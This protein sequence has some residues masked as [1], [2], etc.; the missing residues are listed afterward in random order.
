[1]PKFLHNIDMN[2]NEIQ[3]LSL[4]KTTSPSTDE[5][6]IY[7]NTGDD[8]VRYYQGDGTEVTLGSATGDISEVVA[9]AG[10]SGGAS[11]GSATLAIDIS[12]FS[13]VTPA[14][15]D[16]LLTL[17]SDGATEQLTTIAALATLF[18]GSGL[19]ATNSVIAVDTLNQDTT[20]T[21]AI[22]TTVTV[23]DE[24]SDTTCFP[25]FATA[26]TGDLGPKSGSNLT[27]NSSTGA[28]AASS[29]AG[30]L[31]LDGNT[32]SGIDDSD[33]FTNDD[34]HIMTSAA[35]EDK[36]LGYSYITASSTDTLTNKTITSPDINGGTIDG[37]TIA[38]SDITVGSSK[39]LDVS[40]GTLTLAND[41]I[42]GDKVSGGTIGSI[43]ITA[44]AG[45]LSL[46]D[47]NITNVGDINADSISVDTASGGL[48]IDFSGANTA[49]SFITI[50][51]NLA[52]A[53][54][55]QEGTNDYLDIC[56]TNGSE[57]IQ[58]GHGVSGTAITIGHGT[59]EVTIGDN[60]TVTGDL[61]VSGATTTVNTSTMTVKDPIISL[62]TADDGA[63]PGSDDNKDRGLA[64]HYHTG[65]A[66]KIAFLGFDDSAGDLTFIPDAT[67]SS[68]VVSGTQG[69]INA[70]LSGDVTGNADTATALESSRTFR[71][72]LA[73]TSTAS[74]DGTGNVT[75]GVTGTLAVGNGGTGVTS[76]TN[77][78]NA[79]DDET[80][81]FANNVTITGFVLDSNTITGVDDSS[82]FTDDDNHIMTSA[83]I[84][85]RFAQINADTS[86]EAGSVANALTVD[87]T[88][89]QLNSGTTYNGGAAR[90]ISAKTAAIADSGAALA[91]AD[92]IHT[93]VTTQTDAI[94][95]NTSGTAAGITAGSVGAV[96]VFELTH[97]GSGSGQVAGNSGS[98]SSD[99][100]TWTITHGMGAGRFYK[101]E[102]LL[103]SG[104]YDTVFADVT[105][106]SD[107]TIVITM[108]SAV[109]NGAYRA[110]VQRMA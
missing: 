4:E 73:S 20:G 99:S 44:L 28:L 10:L 3:N 65:S 40:G 27:F 8:T 93:F 92:Q 98:A 9:G 50:G 17:D 33:E 56:T 6:V 52:E 85:D 43:T 103:D 38:T 18:A 42:S 23:A 66:A 81:S 105:R 19:T 79:L 87:N 88:T 96:K 62:G 14:N 76:M 54:V 36:I 41:Q 39:T 60:L 25:L 58:L 82:E 24:S 37:A 61:K 7:Y 31:V 59:S 30:N 46:G 84:N 53:L 55:I 64:M 29:F 57:S 32:I 34:N 83:A 48:N 108:A 74:F 106:P 11:T 35:I 70:N 12:E 16:K 86:G 89:I 100:H 107:T 45:S 26:A 47:N 51:D 5:G 109:A 80:W 13:D 97:V 1:M 75:P 104:N 72:D 67:I 90:T 101:V 71:T 94:A 68:E 22:A 77:L 102:V 78:K 21:A 95:A 110:M 49:K 63:A 2:G 69:T 15:G 91:T